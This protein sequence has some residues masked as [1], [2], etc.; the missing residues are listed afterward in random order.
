MAT[1]LDW[2][3]GVGQEASGTGEALLMAIAGRHG[4]TPDLDGPGTPLLRQRLDHQ[5]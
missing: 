4:I 2:S 5:P 3:S 1:D